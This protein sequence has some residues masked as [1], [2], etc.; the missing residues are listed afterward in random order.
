MLLRFRSF[1]TSHII[2]SSIGHC[3]DAR[4]L[5]LMHDLTI[6]AISMNI[7]ALVTDMWYTALMHVLI[8]DTIVMNTD[9]LDEGMYHT[10][11]PAHVLSYHR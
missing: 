10:H 6:G 4:H 11:D 2:A 9:T 3:T 7:D 1:T 8:K 5:A